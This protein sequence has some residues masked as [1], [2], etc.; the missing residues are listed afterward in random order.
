MAGEAETSPAGYVLAGGRSSCMGSQK[1]LLEIAGSPMV[2]RTAELLAPFCEEVT[3]IGPPEQFSRFGFPVVPD[4]QPGLGPLGGIATVLAHTP[5][6]WNVILACDLPYLTGDWLGYLVARAQASRAQA[7]VPFSEKGPE[8]LCAAYHRDAGGAIRNAIARGLLKVM[9]AL[10]AVPMERIA[11][12]D[13]KPFDPRGLLFQN[14]NSPEDYEQ[15][16]LDIELGGA[17]APGG[18]S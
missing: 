8:P 10:E 5:A 7:V 15:A 1:A 16:R 13:I 3:I 9:G 11:P 6:A 12:A 18:G 17:I 4:D 14:L 2:L